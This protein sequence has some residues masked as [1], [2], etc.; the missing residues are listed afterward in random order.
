VGRRGVWFN[1]AAGKAD[2]LATKIENRMNQCPPAFLQSPSSGDWAFVE[3]LEHSLSKR[4]EYV[5]VAQTVGEFTIEAK[6]DTAPLRMVIPIDFMLSYLHEWADVRVIV[7]SA[8]RLYY[9]VDTTRLEGV[10]NSSFCTWQPPDMVQDEDECDVGLELSCK[11]FPDLERIVQFGQENDSVF[12][13]VVVEF[14]EKALDLDVTLPLLYCRHMPRKER[15][16]HF[17]D[18][19]IARNLSLD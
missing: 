16:L 18:V 7:Q 17:T 10:G 13:K 2:D 1:S 3:V 6:T 4:G 9:I 5:P 8:G 19:F 12:K 14:S 11:I 15:F